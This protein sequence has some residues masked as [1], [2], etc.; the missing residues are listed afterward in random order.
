MMSCVASIVSYCVMCCI[1]GVTFCHVL[2]Q[3]CCMV[4]CVASKVSRGIMC[5]INRITCLVLHQWVSFF[6]TN[7]CHVV[8]CVVQWSTRVVVCGKGYE[9]SGMRV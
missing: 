5:C 7:E 2:H 8:S 6:G 9:N 3:W 4:S 1:N